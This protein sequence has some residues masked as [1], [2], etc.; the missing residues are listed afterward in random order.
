[1]ELIQPA[2]TFVE[3]VT[4]NNVLK[5]N[6]PLKPL[7]AKAKVDK[8]GWLCSHGPQHS[9]KYGIRRKLWKGP[10][11][12]NLRD[13]SVSDSPSTGTTSRST[14]ITVRGTSVTPW[15]TNITDIC[16]AYETP[17]PMKPSRFEDVQL[18]P[19]S[20]SAPLL[21][22]SRMANINPKYR[23]MSYTSTG[24]PRESDDVDYNVNPDPVPYQPQNFMR[25]YSYHGLDSESSTLLKKVT[26][27]KRHLDS[28][29]GYEYTLGAKRGVI[30][31]TD[32]YQTDG[33][34]KWAGSKTLDS[35]SQRDRLRAELEYMEKL[36]GIKRR[37]EVLP[38]R[39]Q[40]DLLM[41]GKR[42]D[43]TERFDIQKE[44][45]KLKSLIMPQ[46]AR[47]LFHGRGFTLPEQH[48]S[49]KPRQQPTLDYEDDDLFS[50]APA[51]LQ[52]LPKHT[53]DTD[54]GFLKSRT[55]IGNKR[56]N[57]SQLPR[58]NNRS[59]TI[60]D[61][62][63]PLFSKVQEFNPGRVERFS[64]EGPWTPRSVTRSGMTPAYL[65]R[66]RTNIHQKDKYYTGFPD[67]NA[68]KGLK[69]TP[70]SEN[71]KRVDI[72][73][74]SQ[75]PRVPH[76][77]AEETPGPLEP[78]KDPYPSEIDLKADVA[79]DEIEALETARDR[80]ASLLNKPETPFKP[81][82]PNP[83]KGS[84]LS[85]KLPEDEQK[86]LKETFKKL[87]TD[88]DGHLMYNQV[89]TQL[90]RLS[91]PQERFLKQVYDITSSSTFFGIE[92]F[93]TMSALTKVVNDQQDA[94][95]E[96]F[97]SLDFSELHHNIVSFID[98]FQTVDRHQ[99]GI[100]SID[101][102]QEV[103]CAAIETDLRSDTELWNTIIDV[104]D[105]ADG[106]QISKVEYLAHLPYFLS[107]RKT[108]KLPRPTRM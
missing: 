62:K 53:I 47:D 25:P 34:L 83:L 55:N 38:H 56:A 23:Q 86:Q 90:P 100:I 39:A 74:A 50:S 68:Q 76:D 21:S 89:Q 33:A 40:L 95:K 27:P 28:F 66:S 80:P 69:V 6:A 91:S 82:T 32:R 9:P 61:G 44:I 13:A 59:S 67:S 24:R 14:V 52:R 85:R 42:V 63:L 99:S 105:P 12:M 98:L 77:V 41:G 18:P 17:S 46:N 57:E 19:V 79:D 102:L 22:V 29:A 87:D 94:A 104:V 20:L 16:K 45:Q 43:L 26:V 1:M 103:L 37:R 70:K 5:K 97:T 88:S 10:S 78:M 84:E 72:P 51:S 92:E 107:L 8:S 7:P 71:V 15:K 54:I 48:A 31:H 75:T 96:A 4:T 35:L 93:M 60:V 30:L 11:P 58:I 2:N 106:V 108:E 64:E 65:R 81:A 36:R 49:L 101:S 3:N 73:S